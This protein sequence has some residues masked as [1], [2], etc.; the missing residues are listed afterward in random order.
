MSSTSPDLGV[1]A[2][3]M[4]GLVLSEESVLDGRETG[5]LMVSA[6]VPQDTNPQLKGHLRGAVNNGASKEEVNAVREFVMR[7]CQESGMK[8]KTEVSKL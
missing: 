3:W 2:K 1:I 4:Y 8:W 5:F 7:I 6:L